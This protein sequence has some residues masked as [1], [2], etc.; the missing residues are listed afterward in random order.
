MSRNSSRETAARDDTTRDGFGLVVEARTAIVFKVRHGRPE[1]PGVSVPTAGGLPTGEE[2]R[3]ALEALGLDPGTA[4]AGGD[5]QTQPV[6]VVSSAGTP[7]VTIDGRS[8]L[9]APAIKLTAFALLTTGS[10]LAGPLPLEAVAVDLFAHELARQSPDVLVLTQ[11]VAGDKQKT[12]TRL[13]QAATF[14]ER[15]VEVVYNG[16]AGYSHKSLDNLAACRFRA[17]ESAVVGG[18]G[19]RLP[20]EALL[21]SIVREHLGASLARAGLG[22]SPFVAL[23]AAAAAAVLLD[24]GSHGAQGQVAVIIVEP[25][26]VTAFVPSDG[27]VEAASASL[28]GTGTVDL[29]GRAQVKPGNTAAEG[30][31]PDWASLA[32]GLPLDLEL[33]EVANLAGD[34]LARPHQPPRNLGEASLSAALLEGLLTRLCAGWETTVRRYTSP[35][36]CRYIVGAGAGLARLG[37]VR[38][39]AACLAGGLLP[40]GV[41][42]LAVDAD[43]LY[44]AGV[45]AELILGRQGWA[46]EGRRPRSVS[47]ARQ[48]EVVATIVSPLAAKLDWKRGNTDPWAVL[49]IEG[50]SGRSAQRRLVPGRVSSLPLAPGEQATLLIEPCFRH[51]DFG[52]GPGRVWRGQVSGGAAGIILDGRGRPFVPASDPVLRLAKQREFLAAFGVLAS[53]GAP[54]PTGDD[55]DGLLADGRRERGPRSHPVARL[56]LSRVIPP[57][58][59]LEVAIG[60]RVTP[61]TVIATGHLDRRVLRLPAGGNFELLKKPG[62]PVKTGE[63]VAVME[64]LL[65]LGLRE[66]VSPYDGV[67]ERI[68]TQ[69]TAI[70]L[71]GADSQHRALVSGVVTRF[72]PTEVDMEVT[73]RRL[74][75]WF[76]F[77]KPVAGEL[78]SPGE[79]ITATDAKRRLG[80]EVRGRVVLGGAFVLPEMLPTL[81]RFGAAAL[82]CGGIDFGPLWDLIAP[83]GE[84]RGGRG[85]PTLVVLGGF[86]VHHLPAEVEKVLEAAAGRAVYVSGPQAGKLVFAGPPWAEVIL[87]EEG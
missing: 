79:I 30:W 9:S 25:D 23:G 14:S 62:D 87:P 31:L 65:G 64:E 44:L 20:T 34:A 75:G 33:S 70:V 48:P 45:G 60:D 7:R 10:R 39:A 82:V 66:F 4:R 15:P 1:P 78:W 74:R 28:T 57:N 19:N 40:S 86:G 16:P 8:S 12:L 11:S 26:E 54:L 50:A 69:R 32:A 53:I 37:D 21:A 76:G 35:S 24:H 38:H 77:G 59:T 13:F 47:S 58:S 42:T 72:T 41:T 22:G 43:C 2:L 29:L 18:R 52:A 5:G 36:R 71:T 46:P 51:L 27:V 83:S 56:T 80:P 68:N 61:D 17:T 67:V 49:T 6:W 81:A 3:S 84:F 85:L 73:G 63:T 55:R